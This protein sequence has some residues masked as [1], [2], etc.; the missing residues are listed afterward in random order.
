MTTNPGAEIGTFAGRL[1]HEGLQHLLAEPQGHE[2][3]SGLWWDGL[4]AGQLGPTSEDPDLTGDPEPR[5][6]LSHRR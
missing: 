4:L 2:P 5:D 6:P 3:V 1:G